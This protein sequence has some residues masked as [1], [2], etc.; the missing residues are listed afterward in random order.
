VW[1]IHI[2]QCLGFYIKKKSSENNRERTKYI[3]CQYI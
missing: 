3:L 1:Y 2:A